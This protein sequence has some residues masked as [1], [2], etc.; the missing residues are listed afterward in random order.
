MSRDADLPDD[1]PPP[2]DE[3]VVLLH[4]WQAMGSP[5]GLWM[6]I[7]P[8]SGDLDVG[9]AAEERKALGVQLAE[10]CRRLEELISRFSPRSEVFR[11]NRDAAQGPVL[12]DRETAELIEFVAFA[13]AF[14]ADA[15]NPIRRR[16]EAGSGLPPSWSDVAF[17]AGRRTFRFL[18]PD[19]MLDLGAIGKGWA[20]ERLAER[21]LEHPL[22][23]TLL[24]AGGSSWL[25]VGGAAD[26]APWQVPLD[27]PWSNREAAADKPPL[28]LVPLR[29]A[30]LSVSWIRPAA[31][32]PGEAA[33]P[34]AAPSDLWGA[35]GAPLQRPQAGCVVRHASPTFAEVLST[36]LLAAEEAPRAALLAR[37]Q[38]D[39]ACAVGW[40][41][42]PGA[43]PRFEWLL[44][45]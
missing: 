12:L 11:I 24:S 40:L 23:P 45:Q 4:S 7:A 28:D 30:G 3:G 34:A 22:P 39:S 20:L 6:R 25:A 15:F 31:P 27:D 26:D 35:D 2:P 8:G 9:M 33:P 5:W 38:S 17:D 13:C 18:R 42:P 19:A 43:S 10:E 36:A 1:P 21:L 32:L 44:P 29:N 14:T 41:R 16:S 37:L